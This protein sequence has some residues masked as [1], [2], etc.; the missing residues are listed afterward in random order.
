MKTS[1]PEAILLCL[2]ATVH[3]AEKLAPPNDDKQKEML[4]VIKSLFKE[5]YASAKPQD[6]SVLAQKL[7]AQ[8]EQMKDDSAAQFVLL[9]E[10]AMS[11]GLAGEPEVAIRALDRIDAAFKFDTVPKTQ[12]HRSCDWRQMPLRK[13]QE[14]TQAH[15]RHDDFLLDK[16]KDPAASAV[17]SPNAI[18]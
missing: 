17:I 11:A 1:L 16:P 13:M 5:L 2:F 9:K 6:K 10:A 14:K 4:T 15:R 3:A 7:L 18:V 8:V 12:A